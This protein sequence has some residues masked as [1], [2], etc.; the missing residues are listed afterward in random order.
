MHWFID[1]VPAIQTETEVE[2]AEESEIPKKPLQTSAASSAAST[3]SRKRRLPEA[4]SSTNASELN[5]YLHEKKVDPLT[6]QKPGTLDI[7]WSMVLAW[8]KVSRDKYCNLEDVGF[9]LWLLT[10]FTLCL[11]F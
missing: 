5:L 9:K 1:S 7:D 11:F 6:L 8:W 2:N 10:Q 3:P 4:T